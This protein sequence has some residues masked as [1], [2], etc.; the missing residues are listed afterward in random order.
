[1]DNNSTRLIPKLDAIAV[2]IWLGM[3]EILFQTG[4]PG[5]GAYVIRTGRIALSWSD[6]GNVYSM[7]IRGPKSVLGLPAVFNGSYSLRAHAVEDSTIGFIPGAR[8]VKLL[9]RCLR[10][11]SEAI[12]ILA[13][14]VARVRPMIAGTENLQYCGGVQ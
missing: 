11:R 12:T 7:G 9:R 2:P 1:M 5:E 3:G 4:D 10:L 6:N 13:R 14:E 8:V